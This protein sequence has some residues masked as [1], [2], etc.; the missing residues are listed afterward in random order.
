MEKEIENYIKDMVVE[1][2]NK[3]SKPEQWKDRGVMIRTNIEKLYGQY[4]SV[5]ISKT[6]IKNYSYFKN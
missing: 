5:I 4:W 6:A 3:F 1:A 2:T